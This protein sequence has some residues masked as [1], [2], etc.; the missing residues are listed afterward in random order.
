MPEPLL[1][2]EK[3]CDYVRKTKRLTIHLQTAIEYEQTEHG[4]EMCFIG[5]LLKVSH[6]ISNR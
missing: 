5:H 3:D 2:Q 4:I 1:Y 6:T